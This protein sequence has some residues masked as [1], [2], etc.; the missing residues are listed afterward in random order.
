MDPLTSLYERLRA[1]DPRATDAFEPPRL[2][3]WLKF[4]NDEDTEL[5]NLRSFEHWLSRQRRAGSP[6]QSDAA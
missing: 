5:G 4:W 6:G 3:E 2:D 1:H